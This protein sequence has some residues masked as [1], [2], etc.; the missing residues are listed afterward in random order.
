MT[1][2]NGGTYAG[3]YPCDGWVDNLEPTPSVKYQSWFHLLSTT[4]RRR[5][6]TPSNLHIERS[7][8]GLPTPPFSLRGTPLVFR[9]KKAVQNRASLRKRKLCTYLYDEPTCP[10]KKTIFKQTVNFRGFPWNECQSFILLF[11][12][13]KIEPF[14]AL[15]FF[16]GCFAKTASM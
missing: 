14:S 11:S 2:A 16:V 8:Q 5:V 13:L 6:Q 1:S 7:Q 4:G 9:T 3:R 12:R 10:V 15:H